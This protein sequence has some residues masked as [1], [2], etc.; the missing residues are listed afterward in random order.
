MAAFSLPL[1]ESIDAPHSVFVRS[2]LVDAYFTPLV[3]RLVL[4][5]IFCKTCLLE[6]RS[7]KKAHC[8]AFMSLS[9]PGKTDSLVVVV[10]AINEGGLQ[11]WP[12]SVL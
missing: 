12:N 8:A 9:G 5:S 2:S 3:D 1:S 10:E 4:F 6:G 11:C 7:K